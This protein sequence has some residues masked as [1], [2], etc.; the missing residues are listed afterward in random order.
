MQFCRAFWSI[1]KF[2][3]IWPNNLGFMTKSTLEYL[4]STSSKLE[5]IVISEQSAIPKVSFCTKNVPHAYKFYLWC[6]LYWQ[7]FI[8]CTENTL[9]LLY[10]TM[11]GLD[12]VQRLQTA[13]LF[14]QEKTAD[15]NETWTYNWWRSWKWRAT[16]ITGLTTD[17]PDPEP[18]LESNKGHRLWPFK[19]SHRGYF[20]CVNVH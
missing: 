10:C 18:P 5:L 8:T 11:H 6:D 1:S 3:I 12:L 4:N 20:V 15:K 13:E 9:I 14:K 7:F 19:E 2:K 17:W 16:T